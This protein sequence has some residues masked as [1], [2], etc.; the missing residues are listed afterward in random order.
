MA[1]K[2]TLHNLGEK[3]INRHQIQWAHEQAIQGPE[4]IT[5]SVK[6][7]HDSKKGKKNWKFKNELGN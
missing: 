1:T 3:K 7:G 4:R 2:I 6:H 5:N